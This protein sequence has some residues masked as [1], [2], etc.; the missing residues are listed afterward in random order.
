MTDRTNDTLRTSMRQIVDMAPSA[1]E[2]PVVQERG[3]ANRPTIA[4]AA[5]FAVVILTVGV[6]AAVI[7]RPFN[8]PSAE[9]TAQTA[10]PTATVELVANLPRI[11]IE[12]AVWNV[13]WAEESIVGVGE[14]EASYGVGYA[15]E[16]SLLRYLHAEIETTTAKIWVTGLAEGTIDETGW[17]GLFRGDASVIN[18]RGH[19]ARILDDGDDYVITWRENPDTLVQVTVNTPG[20][21]DAEA[22]AL[23]EAVAVSLVDIVP[24]EWNSYLGLPKDYDRYSSAT[25]SLP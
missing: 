24:S 11:G 15:V 5:G 23:V 10:V 2:L 14:A 13:L 12:N 16:K 8:T 1:P 17:L 20:M 7:A 18:V 25:T 9:P 19:E 4:L 6:V 21:E 22:D 3:I